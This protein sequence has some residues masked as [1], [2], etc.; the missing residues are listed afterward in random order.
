MIP[1][2][3]FALAT[4]GSAATDGN[5]SPTNADDAVVVLPADAKA[6]GRGYPELA[7]AWWQW[8]FR[9]PDGMRPSQDPTGAQ[10]HD[11]QTG[12]VWFLAGT[13]GTGPV[14][15]NCRVPEGRHL[16]LPVI[17]ALEYSVPGRRRE[18]AALRAAAEAVAGRMVVNRVE[19]D[20]KP[21]EPVRSAPRDCFDA[22]ADA[23]YD[24][25]RPGIYAP[26]YTDGLWMLLPPLAPGRHRLVVDA[27]QTSDVAVRSRFDQQF[28]YVIEVGE[29]PVQE[30]R[31]EPQQD[32]GP[33]VITL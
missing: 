28:T 19:L 26:A 12:D 10:C 23:Q 17:A 30:S 29:A 11:G 14:E 6:E 3:V 33:E 2:L 7:E 25:L 27:R 21:L 24:D 32:E 9:K 5:A 1:A 15:R 8:A 4:L 18:C 16:F 31:D 13:S 22:F 20:G